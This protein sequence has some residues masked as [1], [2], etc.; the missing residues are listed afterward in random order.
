MQYFFEN[1]KA[2]G[3]IS[4]YE[5]S[6]LLSNY[7]QVLSEIKVSILYGFFRNRLLQICVHMVKACEI[8]IKTRI[9]N[10]YRLQCIR[11]KQ[12]S[13]NTK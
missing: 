8:K 6:L 9:S 11:T 5:Q 4:Y 13:H 2:K 7:F 3:E 12:Q 10:G 1:N